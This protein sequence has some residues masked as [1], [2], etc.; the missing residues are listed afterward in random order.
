LLNQAALIASLIDWT[1]LVDVKWHENF[2]S[3]GCAAMISEYSVSF[4]DLKD[5][6]GELSESL[7]CGC[8]FQRELAESIEPYAQ[9]VD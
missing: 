5:A 8:L 2:A 9:T 4:S 1:T 6:I 3:L 7:P